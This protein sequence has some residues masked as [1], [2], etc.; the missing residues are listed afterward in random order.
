MGRTATQPIRLLIHPD[1]PKYA[2]ITSA[3]LKAVKEHPEHWEL[4]FDRAN[5]IDHVGYHDG[6]L[7]AVVWTHEPGTVF[8][9]LILRPGR[10]KV[11]DDLLSI[12][13]S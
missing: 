3:L 12:V 11:Y 1:D 13:L 8:S 5:T 2:A 6:T 10:H 7:S 9:R 4:V